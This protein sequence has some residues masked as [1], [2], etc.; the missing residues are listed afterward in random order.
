MESKGTKRLRSR[1]PHRS[2]EN[3]LEI[4]LVS[5]LANAIELLKVALDAI[6][7]DNTTSL[8]ITQNKK[9][10][11]DVLMR[12]SDT[13]V[14]KSHF[15]NINPIYEL[16][17]VGPLTKTELP[18][19]ILEMLAA[20][21]FGVKSKDR[22]KGCLDIAV[23]NHHYNTVKFLDQHGTRKCKQSTIALLASRPNVPLDLFDI[24]VT[25]ENLNGSSASGYFH[26]YRYRSHEPD[27]LPLHVAVSYGHTKT[28][29]HL[30]KLGARVDKCDSFF[31]L[32]V[33]CFLSNIMYSSRFAEVS[34]GDCAETPV[35]QFN[36]KLFMTLLPSCSDGVVM[37][38]IFVEF[39]RLRPDKTDMNLF[40]MLHQ[41]IQRIKF[42][43]PIKCEITYGGLRRYQHWSIT[44][45]DLGV[46]HT[47]RYSVFHIYLCHLLLFE[48]QFNFASMPSAVP[49]AKQLHRIK[50]KE[51]L[52]FLQAADEMW[53]HQKDRV[54]S[55]HRLCVLCIRNSMRSL[56]DNS[57]LSLPVPLY[58]RR[59]LTFCD[60]SE[61]VFE[62]WCRGQNTP[63]TLLGRGASAASSCIKYSW[64]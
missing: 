44:I 64:S 27:L 30:I 11:S 12:I 29:L 25:A 57:F 22:R 16:I 43:Q 60:V 9:R 50:T 59:L 15:V 31:S 20:A 18:L 4:D 23:E 1:S 38:R 55:L 13:G 53:M 28:T 2:R 7:K 33:N 62:E 6:E 61:K 14:P 19:D 34:T 37:L 42:D 40:E 3:E 63:A 54:R 39:L 49:V 8:D 56:D 46:G 48:Q 26:S 21:G 24:L 32:P 35:I 58:I 45:N 52:A 51:D 17:S 5:Q 10:I 41:V 47:T 36:H